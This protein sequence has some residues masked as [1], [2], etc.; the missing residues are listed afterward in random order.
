[1]KAAEKEARQP[2]VEIEFD[3]AHVCRYCDAR[4]SCSSYR[5]YALAS[6]A[7]SEAAF[8]QYLFD[9]GPDLDQQD[10]LANNLAAAETSDLRL[11]L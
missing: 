4:F 5:R 8:R 3:P 2:I 10:W 6:S 7:H 9:Y 11:D 1:M